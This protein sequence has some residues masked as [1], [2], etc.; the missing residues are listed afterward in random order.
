M[1]F[2]LQEL[3]P[4]PPRE[5]VVARAFNAALEDLRFHDRLYE[6]I[7]LAADPAVPATQGTSLILLWVDCWTPWAIYAGVDPY[8]CPAASEILGPLWG[9]RQRFRGD[10]AWRDPAAQLAALAAAYRDDEFSALPGEVSCWARSDRLAARR[11]R[12]VAAIIG[13]T[14]AL[15]LKRPPER[16]RP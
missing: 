9:A 4:R 3:P 2:R 16:V 6:E 13:L 15:G 1:S 5:L 14:V 10:P 8:E 11:G 12:Q 7:L